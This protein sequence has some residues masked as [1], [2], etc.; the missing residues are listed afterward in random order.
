VAVEPIRLTWTAI[1]AVNAELSTAVKADGVPDVV[2]GILRGGLIP[3]VAMCHQLNI[4][5]LRAVHVTHTISDDIGAEKT[6]KPLRANISSL[7]DLTG[8]HVLIVDDIAGTGDTILDATNL[9]TS[10]GVATVR[11]AVC[12]V[13]TANWKQA[14]LPRRQINYIGTIVDR[15][16]VFPWEAS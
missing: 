9:V 11:T 15:W 1:A 14:L 3:A 4:R 2:V 16:V 13:N 5:D 7:G 6:S 10:L 12:V 8:Q